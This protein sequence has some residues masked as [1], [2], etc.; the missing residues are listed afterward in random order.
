M[1]KRNPPQAQTTLLLDERERIELLALVEA[2][3]GETRVE[4]HRT[5]SPDF[6]E[7]VE[8]REKTLRGLIDKLRQ[9]GP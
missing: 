8:R 4:V 9:S 6:R 1:P 3:L 7:Q 5:H 2:A